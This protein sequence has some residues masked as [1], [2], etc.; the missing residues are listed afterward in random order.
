MVSIVG[1]VVHLRGISLRGV[2]R[3]SRL[4]WHDRHGG[5][6]AQHLLKIYRV[7]GI[8]GGSY[9][10]D[11]VVCRA[12]FGQV[13]NMGASSGELVGGADGIRTHDLP[14]FTGTR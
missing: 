2:R 13:L 1:P 11:L 4:G 8:L 7:D 5:Y 6:P 12:C 9:S 3:H 10:S 14:G